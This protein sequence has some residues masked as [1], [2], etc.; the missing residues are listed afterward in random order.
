MRPPNWPNGEESLPSRTGSGRD[1]RPALRLR[2]LF[3]AT[4]V[5]D[6]LL[7]GRV[8]GDAQPCRSDI[9]RRRQ[10]VVCGR[11]DRLGAIPRDTELG[12]PVDEPHEP[13]LIGVAPFGD[14]PHVARSEDVWLDTDADVD[15]PGDVQ[16]GVVGGLDEVRDGGGQP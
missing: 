3:R 15:V 11:A 8:T 2:A 16:P 9:R 7:R 1:S 5:E 14:G 4:P 10:N 6:D 13:R 12:S